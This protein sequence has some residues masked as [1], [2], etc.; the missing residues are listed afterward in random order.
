MVFLCI[1]KEALRFT[2]VSVEGLV[3]QLCCVIEKYSR[4]FVSD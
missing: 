2:V 1:D 4:A 3:L